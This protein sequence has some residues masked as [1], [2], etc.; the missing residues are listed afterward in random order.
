MWRWVASCALAS[1]LLLACLAPAAAAQTGLNEAQRI[2]IIRTLIAKVGI[3]RQPLPPDKHGVEIGPDGQ[4]LN[5]GG[6]EQTLMDKGAAATRGARVAI[7]AINFKSDR[8]EFAIN[9]GPH[10][11]HWY[12]H[13]HIGMSAT[14]PTNNGAAAM[15][16]PRGALITLRFPHATPTLTPEQVESYLA[17][18]IDWDRPSKAMVMVQRI[19]TAARQAIQH[20]QVL[21][22]MTQSMVVASLGR[23]GNKI[24]SE[25]A[26]GR[27]VQDWVYGQPPETTFVRMY[28][29]RV[30]RVTIW[31]HGVKTVLTQAPPALAG[32]VQRQQKQEAQA[33]QQA[34]QPAP[35]LRRPGDPPPP[36]LRP[37]APPPMQT[38]PQMP[39]TPPTGIP[40]QPGQQ[41]QPP[42]C[43]RFAG[44]R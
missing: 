14:M 6:V 7:T 16:G 4:I 12:D 1:G 24:G 38:A 20:H 35:T 34:S 10:Q 11:T 15:N 9:G 36:A 31:H 28:S 23:T 43:C 33:E 42:V 18:L 19:P 21:V 41:Q 8:I 13:L 44:L 2:A 27:Q 29:G 39:Q 26:Q 5:A 37:G 40:T 17:P 3:A 22:G 25:D 30:L 32:A